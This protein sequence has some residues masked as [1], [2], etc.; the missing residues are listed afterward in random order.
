MWSES[1]NLMNQPEEGTDIVPEP[2]RPA[3]APHFGG[4]K[5]R[6]P[7]REKVLLLG[8]N[9]TDQKPGLDAMLREAPR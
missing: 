9:P 2:N 3:E 5:V 4:R 7:E 8:T 6:L 1:P